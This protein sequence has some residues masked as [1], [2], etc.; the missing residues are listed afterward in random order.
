MNGGQTTAS[1]HRAK[2]N[3]DVDVSKILVPTKITIVKKELRNIVPKISRYSNSQNI[4][5]QSDF[6]SDNPYHKKIKELSQ[7]IFIPGESGNGILK[8]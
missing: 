5:K 6:H 7:L 4:V 2:I 1:I 8:N 3:D